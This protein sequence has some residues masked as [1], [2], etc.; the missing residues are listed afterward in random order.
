MFRFCSYLGSF[1]TI[2]R[3][4]D[5]GDWPEKMAAANDG[6][7]ADRRIRSNTTTSGRLAERR[8]L[9]KRVPSLKE[10]KRSFSSLRRGSHT[11]RLQTIAFLGDMEVGKTCIISRM[12]FDYFSNDYE[13]TMEDLHD[14]KMNLRGTEETIQVVDTNGDR[15]EEVKGIRHA[16]I[17]RAN[18]FVVVFNVKKQTSFIRAEQILSEIL[19]L[20]NDQG[21]ELTKADLGLARR[22]VLVGNQA[23]EDPDDDGYDQNAVEL[24]AVRQVESSAA[25]DLAEAYGIENYIE[26]SAMTGLGVDSIPK[27][28]AALYLAQR[29]SRDAPAK[30]TSTS[31]LRKG[32]GKVTSFLRRDTASATDVSTLP[33]PH[34]AEKSKRHSKLSVVNPAES[35]EVSP[36]PQPQATIKKRKS[37]VDRLRKRRRKKSTTSEVSVPDG[38]AAAAASQNATSKEQEQTRPVSLCHSAV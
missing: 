38:A 11:P 24:C 6:E 7:R 22:V 1:F 9:H 26:V 13:P 5:R 25:W 33:R 14:A 37:I 34:N 10:I 31:T 21:R 16:T 27:R 23:D 20:S 32:L 35:E 30:D 12:L 28:L 8:G 18:G 2:T 15:C 36:S 4:K 19:E 29:K 17:N 3:G